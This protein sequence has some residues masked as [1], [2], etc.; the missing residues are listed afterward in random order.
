MSPDRAAGSTAGQTAAQEGSRER[1]KGE[2]ALLKAPLS[3]PQLPSQSQGEVSLLAEASKIDI[4]F[5]PCGM[6][7]PPLEELKPSHFLSLRPHGATAGTSPAHFHVSYL[8]QITSRSALRS[9]KAQ[10][11]EQRQK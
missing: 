7:D 6:S 8:G 1:L 10:A 5:K 2:G 4:F 9:P 11:L 3:P